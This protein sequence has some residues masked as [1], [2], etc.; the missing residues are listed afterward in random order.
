M[1]SVVTSGAL[2][3]MHVSECARDVQY[4]TRTVT[5]NLAV[6]ASIPDFYYLKYGMTF[7]RTLNA[8]SIASMDG[9]WQ[10][11]YKTM[12]MVDVNLPVIEIETLED[13]LSFG[14]KQN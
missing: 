8:G 14:G 7:F 12:T 3:D 10:T 2:V 1:Y 5:A 13:L 9:R 6:L 11:L 4:G